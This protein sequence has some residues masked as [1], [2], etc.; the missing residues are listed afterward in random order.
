MTDALNL[1]FSVALIVTSW[2]TA[3]GSGLTHRPGEVITAAA[4]GS[5]FG[6][7]IALD[8]IAIPLVVYWARAGPVHFGGLHGWAR[9]RGRRFRWRDRARRRSIG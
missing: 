9:P 8:V 4:D 1:A 5:R 7:L 2:A 3:V 6:R